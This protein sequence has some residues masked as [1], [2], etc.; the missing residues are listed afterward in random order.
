LKDAVKKITRRNSPVNLVKVI[1]DLN[2]VLRGFA[3]YFNIANCSGVFRE[4]SQW[5]RRRLRAK[6]M[7]LWK[8][9]KRLHRRLR[10]LGYKGEFMKIK[11]SSWRN[12]ASPLAS[13]ALPNDYFRELG[14]FDLSRVR[15]G[16]TA[17]VT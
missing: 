7:N 5:I 8:R 6:Q 17:S 9:P 2:P 12:S 14:L 15:T 10:Q 13:L 1:T 11:M 4:L 3:N 16:A